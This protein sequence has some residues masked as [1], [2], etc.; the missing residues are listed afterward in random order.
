M[1]T[2]QLTTIPQHKLNL[3]DHRKIELLHLL[4]LCCFA[5]WKL[6]NCFCRLRNLNFCLHLWNYQ[7]Y[8]IKLNFTNNDTMILTYYAFHFL[9]L[10]YLLYHLHRH[11]SNAQEVLM[12]YW[13]CKI[14]PLDHLNLTLKWVDH[15][16]GYNE[17]TRSNEN[18]HLFGL[19]LACPENVRPKTLRNHHLPL[20]RI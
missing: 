8:F 4:I 1:S 18:D 13:S 16:T 10:I 19:R 15:E 3:H 2:D 6:L 20:N 7:K 17:L 11:R 14:K 12:R 9:S 5:S